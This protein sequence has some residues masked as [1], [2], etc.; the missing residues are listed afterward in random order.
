MSFVREVHARV[1]NEIIVKTNAKELFAPDSYDAT[2]VHHHEHK[3][4]GL[5]LLQAEMVIAFMDRP[6]RLARS[7]Q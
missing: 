4:W 5:E 7:S 3:D 1:K 6:A 2:F